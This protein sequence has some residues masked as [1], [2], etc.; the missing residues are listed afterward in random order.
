MTA[1]TPIPGQGSQLNS[2]N[3]SLAVTLTAADT[4][5]PCVMLTNAGPNTAFVR[6]GIGAQTALAASDMPV[7][8]GGSGVFSKGNANMIASVTAGAD[9]AVVNLICGYGE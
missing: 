8:A 3:V 2:S 9:M 7:L 6:W 4:D 1:F 5:A